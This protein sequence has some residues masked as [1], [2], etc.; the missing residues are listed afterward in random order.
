MVNRPDHSGE[1]RFQLR[2]QI[3]SGKFFSEDEGEARHEGPDREFQD[4]IGVVPQF[5]RQEITQS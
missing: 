1:R 2:S 4:E 5:A 3:I